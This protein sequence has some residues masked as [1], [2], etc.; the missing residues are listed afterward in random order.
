MDRTPVALLRRATPDDVT[1]I[2]EFVCGLSPRS[3]YLRFFAAVAPPSTGLLR[4]LCGTGGAD[5]LLVV[6]RSGA[7]IGHGMAAD[8]AD[9]LETSI[10]LV[11]ADAW[12]RRGVGT[13]VLQALASRAARRGVDSLVLEVLPDNRVMRGIIARRWPDAPAERRQ[14]AIVY[15]PAIGQSGRC[16]TLP[17]AVAIGQRNYQGD[18]RAGDRPAA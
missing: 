8:A 17:R 12:Q 6:D 3:Q 9:G 18:H 2:R 7:V 5:V 1:S 13:Q 10:G 16:P 14:D 4:A 11:V 15:R